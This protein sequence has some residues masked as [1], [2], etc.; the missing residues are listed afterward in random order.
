MKG[1]IIGSINLLFKINFII[2]PLP[3]HSKNRNTKISDICRWN[4]ERREHE[5]QEEGGEPRD[6]GHGH[7]RHLLA[8]HPAHPPPQ[9][10]RDVQSHNLQHFYT[11]DIML[12]RKRHPCHSLALKKPNKVKIGWKYISLHN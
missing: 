8:P 9:V 3:R 12:K 11:G 10:D 7:V 6:P 4:C 2:I 5:E 1:S